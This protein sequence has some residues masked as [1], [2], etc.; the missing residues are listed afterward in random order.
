MLKTEHFGS[1]AREETAAVKSDYDYD[2]DN[3]NNNYN[4]SVHLRTGDLRDNR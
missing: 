4:N 1:F 2:D 3:N